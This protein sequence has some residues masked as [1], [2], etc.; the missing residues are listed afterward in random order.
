MAAGTE[1]SA[2]IWLAR[3]VQ[4]VYDRSVAACEDGLA[5]SDQPAHHKKRPFEEEYR[6]LLRAYDVVHEE[7]HLFGRSCQPS[8][9][10]LAFILHRLPG[11]D[12]SGYIHSPLTTGGSS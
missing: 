11:T 5:R 8:L 3:S 9:A 12:V 1:R 4:R 7:Q 10:G 2:R 6:A